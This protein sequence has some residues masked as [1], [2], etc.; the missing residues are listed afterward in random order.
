MGGGEGSDSNNIL[1]FSLVHRK[2]RGGQN[3]PLIP[4]FLLLCGCVCGT[5]SRSRLL[6]LEHALRKS[7]Y[8]CCICCI[9][10]VSAR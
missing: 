8:L 3:K 5:I 6:L 1:M 2:T 7:F 4:S 10:Y 9:W